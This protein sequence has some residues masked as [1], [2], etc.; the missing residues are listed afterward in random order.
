MAD[1]TLSE[2]GAVAAG[3]TNRD[4]AGVIDFWAERAPDAGA[5]R[6]DRSALTYRALQRAIHRLADQWTRSGLRP[7]ARIAI[8]GENDVGVVVAI[9]AAWRI[10]AWAVPLNARYT[11][12][13]LD[14]ILDHADPDC[15]V[16]VGAAQARHAD[17]MAEP[18]S[19]DRELALTTGGLRA[20]TPSE[21]D[22]GS[23]ADRVVLM[24]YTSGTTGAPKGVM[25][26]HRALAYMASLW[27]RRPIVP[28][29][30]VYQVLPLSHSYGLCSYLFGA[31]NLG[32]E[33]TLVSRFDAEALRLALAD[34]IALFQGVPAMY[35]R[36]LAHL[37]ESGQ[38][39]RA[40]ALKMISTGGAPLDPGLKIAVE[41]TFGLGLR[42]AYGLTE[43]G[44]TATSPAEPPQPATALGRAAPGAEIRLV[45]P[46]SGQPVS[47]G[48]G[49]IW[50]RSPGVMRGYFRNPAAT[51]EALTPDGW[52][53]TGDL[54]RF[55]IDGVLHLVGRAKD[56][57]IRSGF[58]VYPAEIEAVLGSHPDVVLA[59]VVG[60]PEPQ[61]DE[62][63]VAFVQLVAGATSSS[64]TLAQH[65]AANLAGYKRPAEVRIEESLPLGVNGKISMSE[66]RDRLRREASGDVSPLPNRPGALHA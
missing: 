34:G 58:N 46:E 39:H 59:A 44:P 1:Q 50:V 47:D 55:E 63:V 3:A 27:T 36:Y 21:P 41:R 11:A 25:L 12:R 26:P 33:V 43:A 35:A 22:A 49:E 30:R 37:A 10:G 18:T 42:Q 48:A 56:I 64:D 28:G 38:A 4:L 16:T 29:D 15:V 5:I 9:F 13:E 60:R 65:C 52:L 14:V 7:G 51:L 40:P 8:I 20:A 54:A 32:C 57:I 53:K 31:L 66:L 6:D 61:G 62:S 2:P 17:R 45:D 23:A 24:L 19:H